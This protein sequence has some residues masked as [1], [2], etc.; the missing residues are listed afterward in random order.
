MPPPSRRRS[1][2]AAL[3]RRCRAASASVSRRGR[4]RGGDLAM[5]FWSSSPSASG[6]R[7]LQRHRGDGGTFTGALVAGWSWLAAA[8]RTVWF[9]LGWRCVAGRSC[10]F[11]RRRRSVSKDLEVEDGPGADPRPVRHSDRWALRCF[12]WWFTK[13]CPGDGVPSSSGAMVLLRLLAMLHRRRRAAD[14]GGFCRALQG[15]VRNF[16]LPWGLFY[17]MYGPTCPSR[18][19]CR[20]VR[21]LYGYCTL[22]YLLI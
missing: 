4:R 16:V 10:D 17:K 8:G 19:F 14:S 6:W 12:L 1:C 3:S 15:L 9:V 18:P 22:F 2:F 13:P 20:C 11:P 5:D 21:V 7:L